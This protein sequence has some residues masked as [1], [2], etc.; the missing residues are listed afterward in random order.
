M[1]G[2]GRYE[3]TGRGAFVVANRDWDPATPPHI[4]ATPEELSV[5]AVAEAGEDNRFAGTAT[6]KPISVHAGAS[7]YKPDDVDI[8]EIVDLTRN[9][10]VEIVSAVIEIGGFLGLGGKK[11]AVPFKDLKVKKSGVKAEVRVY[12]DQTEDELNGS[13]FYEE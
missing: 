13:P 10:D 4:G 2:N 3:V 11:V 9:P 1:T 8:G 5:T 12:L 6:E 7:V